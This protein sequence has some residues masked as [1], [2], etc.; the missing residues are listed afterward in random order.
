[1]ESG[2]RSVPTSVKVFGILHTVF[3]SFGL[4]TSPFNFLNLD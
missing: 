2:S 1:M 4:V 3:G